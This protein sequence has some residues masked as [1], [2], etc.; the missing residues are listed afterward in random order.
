[1]CSRFFIFIFSV[2]FVINSYANSD[3][4]VGSISLGTEYEVALQAFRAEYGKP[5]KVDNAKVEYK[6][7]KYW[8]VLFDKVLF[9]F[10]EGKFN[11]ARFFIYAKNKSVA[12]KNLSLL[13]QKMGTV[14]ELAEDYEEGSFFYMGGLPPKGIGH[15]F[16]ISIANR[17]GKWDTELTYGPF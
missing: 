1:M 12:I 5:I 11:E 4:K 2:F 7:I 17:Q 9:K 15:L 6:K 3:A 8:G 10:K 13:A 16:T 14:Y